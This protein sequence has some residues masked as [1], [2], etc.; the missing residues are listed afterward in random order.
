MKDYK[1]SSNQRRNERIRARIDPPMPTHL[2]MDK[3]V[4]LPVDDE[5]PMRGDLNNPY[6][7]ETELRQQEADYTNQF[8]IECNQ[9]IRYEK[10]SKW[11]KNKW[12]KRLNE[13]K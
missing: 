7:I 5:N 3:W 11:L 4:A 6:T 10:K 13:N 12:E 8:L 1:K 2:R 9:N